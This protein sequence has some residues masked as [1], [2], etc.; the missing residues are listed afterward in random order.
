[1]M[2]SDTNLL[3]AIYQPCFLVTRTWLQRYRHHENAIPL[4]F[5]EELFWLKHE[6]VKAG[7]QLAAK[8][9]WCLETIGKVQQNFT[10]AFTYIASSHFKE[11]WDLLE[12][13]Q[14]EINSLDKH[15]NEQGN[16]FG[17]EHIRVHSSQ[18]RGAYPFRIG[19]SPGVLRKRIR[20]SICNFQLSLRRRCNHV[21]GEIYDGEM[22]HNIIEQAKILHISL[23]D[24]PRHQYAVIFPEGSDDTRLS[25]LKELMC[26][27]GTPW[28]CWDCTQE[29]RR[30]YP[31]K[32][33][34]VRRNE[35]CPCGS[36]RKYKRCCLSKETV[37]PHCQ[38]FIGEIV[39]S[40]EPESS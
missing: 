15:F 38:I 14:I 23:V 6:A 36:D 1:M 3:G 25:H 2:T 16:E 35:P 4:N 9:A 11:G 39:G 7:D 31:T 21:N 19:F 37:S 28:R 13:C 27:L 17:I 30:T 33:S 26:S 29:T 12:R 40:V 8:A 5:W 20:C 24:N 32:N 22:C 34:Q 10:Q 18:L